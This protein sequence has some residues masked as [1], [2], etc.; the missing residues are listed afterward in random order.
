MAHLYVT[1]HTG[2]KHKNSDIFLPSFTKNYSKI[3]Y[4]CP[5]K[6]LSSYLKT[7]LSCCGLSVYNLALFHGQ[8]PSLISFR[9]RRS[10][11]TFLYLFARLV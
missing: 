3:K 1:T 9:I 2:Y 11:L 10:S 8:R 6:R 7:V 4:D 5:N